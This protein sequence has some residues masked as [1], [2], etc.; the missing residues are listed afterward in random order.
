[1]I[2]SGRKIGRGYSLSKEGIAKKEDIKNDLSPENLEKYRKQNTA[3]ISNIIA[4]SFIN[5]V[6]LFEDEDGDIHMQSLGEFT[7]SG[8]IEDIFSIFDLFSVRDID[9]DSETTELYSDDLSSMEIHPRVQII[10]DLIRVH[11]FEDLKK[12]DYGPILKQVLE[13]EMNNGN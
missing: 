1:M 7:R 9:F 11:E 3:K 12:M 2:L 4:T 6:F 13:W 10:R 8:M 5:G